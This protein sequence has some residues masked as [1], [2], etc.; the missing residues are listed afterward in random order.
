MPQAVSKK[1]FRFMMALSHGKYDPA[2]A[3]ARGAPPKEVADK[4]SSPGRGAAEQSGQDRGGSWTHGHH[5]KHHK[6]ESKKHGGKETSKGKHHRSMAARHLKEHRK[7]LNKAFDDYYNGSAAAALLINNDNQ[8]CLG[9]HVNGGLAFS[10]GHMDASDISKEITALRELKEEMGVSGKNPQKIWSGKLNGNQ[11]DVFI[12][13]SW[14]GEPKST[15]EIKDPK[16]YNVE[17]IPWNK[18]RDCCVAPL[19][20]FVRTKLGKSL[21]DML[22]LENLEKNIVRQKSDAVFEVTHGDALRIV[23]NGMFRK[24]RNFV[25]DMKDEE[26]KDMEFDTHKIHIRKHINDVYS[27]RVNDGHKTI[28]QFTNKS[29]PELTVAL[30][31]VFEWY[32]P[33]DEEELELL[34]DSKLSD[35]ALEGGIDSLMDNYKKHNIGNIYQEMENIREQIRNGMAVD[36]QQVEA[37]MMTLFDKLE[38]TVHSITGKHNELAQLAGKEVDDIES[39][40]RDLQAKIEEMERR[41]ET[42]E[43]YTQFKSNPKKIHD[44]NYPYLPKPQ[45]EVSPD[46]KIKITFAS[47]WTHLEKDNFLHDLKAKIIKRGQK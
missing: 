37:R 9:R 24:L 2:K 15:K 1:Q 46:G 10:G 6:K 22:S 35:E 14:T 12:V 32:M 41:P 38:E 7:D 13:E 25:K 45:I 23:G 21:R 34:D 39:K 18:L 16:W 8:I 17:D 40:L 11:S 27:G 28:Y 5:A 19:E 36:L 26:F 33:E 4:Y 30:M 3:P 43:A 31:S 44:D 20:H 42:I 29:L 47:E